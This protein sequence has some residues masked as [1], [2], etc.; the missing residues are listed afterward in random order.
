MTTFAPRFELLVRL[1]RL[2]AGLEAEGYLGQAKLYRGISRGLLARA[3]YEAD[4]LRIS[5]RLVDEMALA[6]AELQQV[7]L[8]AQMLAALDVAQSVATAQRATL[9]DEIGALHVCRLCGELFL[10]ETPEYCPTCGSHALAYWEVSPIYHLE[11][12][13][14]ATVLAA[15]ETMPAALHAAIDG[16][17]EAQ[18][19]ASPAPGEWSLRETIFHLLMAQGVLVARTQLLLTE[20]HP[21]LASQAVWTFKADEDVSTGALVAQFEAVRRDLL[22]TLG[23]IPYDAWLRSG[24]HTEFGEVTLLQQASYFA[25]HERYHQPQLNAIRAAVTASP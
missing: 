17:S 24:W 11:P 14:P 25:K 6:R 21:S 1:E 22:A 16:L 8:A 5:H 2:A 12:M 7:G 10:N 18:M 20:A 19:T 13:T 9:W 4:P 3:A 15:L 23:G